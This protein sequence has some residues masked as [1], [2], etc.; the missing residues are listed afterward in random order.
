MVLPNLPETHFVYWGGEAAGIVAMINPLL[1][2]VAIAD[3][4]QCRPRQGAGHAGPVPR[5]GYLDQGSGRPPGAGRLSSISSSP[6]WRIAPLSLCGPRGGLPGAAV[7]LAERRIR[8]HRLGEALDAQDGAA[9]VSGRVITGGDRSL[10]FLYRRHDGSAKNRHAQPW[11]R[12]GQCLER[13]ALS[14]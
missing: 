11:Q 5:H 6:A 13:G 10:L 4:I 9:L 2:T 3:L 12:G 7:G 8:L 14:G 1:E